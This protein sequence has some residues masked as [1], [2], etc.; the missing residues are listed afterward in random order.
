MV[1]K[2]L[3]V[4]QKNGAGPVI[5][6]I[7]RYILDEHKQRGFEKQ[8][9]PF[10]IT[11]NIRKRGS[12]KD[13]EKE[14][15][16]VQKIRSYHRVDEVACFHY[17]ISIAPQ[18]A[19]YVTDDML[20]SIAKEFIRLRAPNALVVGTKHMEKG[21][22]PHLHLVIS[23]GLDGKSSRISNGDFRKLKADMQTFQLSHYPKLEHS[24]VNL[25][26]SPNGKS[27]STKSLAN[28]R[29]YRMK[30]KESVIRS[31]YEAYAQS[32]S[33]GDFFA[34]L[35]GSGLEF[36]KRNGVVSGIQIEGGRKYRFTTLGLETEKIQRLDQL[37]TFDQELQ[38]MRKLREKGKG[39]DI[40]KDTETKAPF[41]DR[42]EA[43]DIK[44]YG[45]I[46]SRCLI[47][48]LEKSPLG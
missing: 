38:T 44:G 23:S 37:N 17:I 28:L 47:P 40:A 30:E 29:E 6:Y 33:S 24:V 27:P 1:I 3:S 46:P 19:I 9:K 36:Y 11:H 35:K 39:K 18:D 8:T 12:I 2:S 31:V 13:F 20:K 42:L 48:D 34:K 7:F 22:H 43:L 32:R 15:K 10:I 16:A 45:E 14:F 21:K 26:R 41:K 25:D 5:K 4:K